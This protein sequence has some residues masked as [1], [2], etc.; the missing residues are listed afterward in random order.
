MSK[1]VYAVLGASGHS[2]YT[3]AEHDYYATNPITVPELLGV[4]EFKG[5]VWEPFCGEGHISKEQEK[6]GYQV[7][8]SDLIERGYG[9]GGKDIFKCSVK[10]ADNV[11]SNPPYNLALESVEHL[12]N[13]GVGK[14]AMFLK[15][16][17]LESQKRYQF[18]MDNPPKK[19][20][21]YSGRRTVARNGDEKMF[22]ASS[23]ICYAWFVWEAG[24][25]GS[26]EIG[27]IL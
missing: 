25:K 10:E 5:S 6:Q 4:E 24:Y 17:F 14:I 11:I 18:F 20:W 9:E 1:N 12:L 22:Q 8:S 3:R 23:A 2:D 15:I 7:T 21:V 13:L 26:P 16:T 19:V 27:W